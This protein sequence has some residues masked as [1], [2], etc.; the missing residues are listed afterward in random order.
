[1]AEIEKVLTPLETI[2]KEMDFV[3][4]EVGEITLLLQAHKDRE[5]DTDSY[6][7][8]KEKIEAKEEINTKVYVL[9]SAIVY[10]KM[11]IDQTLRANVALSIS[12]K[13]IAYMKE[14]SEYLNCY[15]SILYAVSAEMQTLR[16]LMYVKHPELRMKF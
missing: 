14:L 6:V 5:F 13:V 8:L 1:M 12:N 11:T 4:E 16:E 2:Y 3:Y 15:R 9:I 10:A 7:G